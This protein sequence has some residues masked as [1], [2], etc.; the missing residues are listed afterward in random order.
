[1]RT[2]LRES[3]QMWFGDGTSKDSSQQVDVWLMYELQSSPRACYTLE[4]FGHKLP[5]TPSSM[6]STLV[7]YNGLTFECIWCKDPLDR[8]GPLKVHGISIGW[9]A[10]SEDSSLLQLDRFG[11]VKLPEHVTRDGVITDIAETPDNVDRAILGISYGTLAGLGF[12]PSG[13][14][15]PGQPFSYANSR[16]GLR[17]MPAQRLVYGDFEVVLCVPSKYWRGLVSKEFV[18]EIGVVGI[19]RLDGQPIKWPRIR[20]VGNVITRFL[21]WLGHCQCEVFHIKGYTW[22]RLVRVEYSL[23]PYVTPSREDSSLLPLDAESYVIERLFDGYVQAFK[24]VAEGRSRFVW[25]LHL[26]GRWSHDN[27]VDSFRD[28]IA[29]C[30]ILAKLLRPEVL[31]G[32]RKGR[33][34]LV[35]DILDILGID[36]KVAGS[37]DA[38]KGYERLWS[39]SK[40]GG[41]NQEALNERRLSTPIGNIADWIIHPEDPG[42]AEKLGGLGFMQNLF[43]HKCL[44]LADLLVL[45]VIK[46]DGLYTNRSTGETVPVPWNRN[47]KD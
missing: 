37:K 40:R 19:R 2:I 15:K 41:I 34:A 23:N 16:S 44:L 8:G 10:L 25:A 43:L 32:Y 26:L 14:A 7:L 27:S 6:S 1:M 22:G 42:N 18:R 45:K 36:D 33:I 20:E 30:A 38:Y 24:D 13:Y 9:D 28:V 17:D 5:S 31:K 3:G 35:E 47:C 12:T 29:A 4:I 39:R 11:N 46:Y 21:T